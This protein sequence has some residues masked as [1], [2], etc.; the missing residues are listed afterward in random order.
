MTSKI[1][2]TAGEETEKHEAV[3]SVRDCQE[4]SGPHWAIKIKY[5]AE[6]QLGRPELRANKEKGLVENMYPSDD[7][8]YTKHITSGANPI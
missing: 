3:P 6:A 7:N 4:A 1:M 8:K 2:K 5:N